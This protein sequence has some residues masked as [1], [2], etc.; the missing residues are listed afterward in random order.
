MAN[1]SISQLTAGGAVA[2]TDLFPDVQTVGV[3][4]VKVTA[5]QIGTYVLTG[6]F[7]SGFTFNTT[8]NSLTLGVQST[9]SAAGSLILANEN[10][11]N[12]PT[13]LKSSNSASAAWTLTL[14]TTAGTSGYMF[15][16]DGSGNASWSNALPATA[17]GTLL[18]L[19][20]QGGAG[21]QGSLVL[22]N[23]GSGAV[24]VQ[25]S[26]STS[27]A[28]T[29]TLPV[30]AGTNGF[31]LTTNGSGVTAWTNPTALG[32]D[33]DVGTT[34]VTNGNSGRV[35]YNNAGVLGE[36]TITGTA[37]SVVLSNS[38]TFDDDI[39]LG[40]QQ[41]TQGSIVLANTAAGAFSTTVRSSNSASA[42]WTLTLPVTA[43]SASYVLA[44]DGSGV[45]SWVQAGSISTGFT[46]GSVVFAG[47]SGALS[48]NN[49]RFFW[50][51]SNFRLG[52]NTA[53]PAVTIDITATDAIRVPVGN[54]T[55]QRPAGVT[56]YIR[57]NTDTGKFEGY[58]AS[59]W[60]NIGGGAAITDDTTT[61]NNWYPT[62]ASVTTGDLTT[63]Y[64]SS[65]KLTYN[66]ST[67]NLLSTAVGSAN[68]IVLNANTVSANYTVPSGYNGLSGGPVTVNSGIT[69]TVSSGSVWTVV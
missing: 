21:P 7:D 2:G 62:F 13:T 25:S 18:T 10:A 28:W 58:G 38:P 59:S 12:Y 14:P 34:P 19:G 15:V 55:T 11:S 46:Q 44:T 40:T 9:A 24:T 35:L 49:S 53:T 6:V 45:T 26:N 54:G 69:V 5:Q 31:I 4:P 47:A 22:A 48:Q 64:V 61:N 29:M 67:G 50:D 30:S 16:T 36:Y 17:T 60:G 32:I 23:L 33:L 56:G 52:I 65:A 27:A 20:L 43:G 42:A 37:G 1:K 41:T 66:P 8:A 63:V 3:G 57:Y 51:N 68:G 39:T